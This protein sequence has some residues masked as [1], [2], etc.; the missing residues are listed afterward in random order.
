[1]ENKLLSKLKIILFSACLWGVLAHGMTLFN[2]YSFNDDIII[3]TI[4]TTYT[5]GRWMLAIL[6]DMV[7]YFTGMYPVS[8]PLFNGIFTIVFIALICVLV[9]ALLD[10]ENIWLNIGLTGMMIAFPVITGLFGFAFTAPYYLFGML[11]GVFG[12]FLVCKYSKW[13]LYLIGI[14]LMACSVGVYQANI[15]VFVSLILIYLIKV[16]AE[17]DLRWKRFLGFCIYY[18][19]ACIGFLVMYLGINKFML[20][21]NKLQLS[22]YKGINTFG[23]TSLGG[24]CNR[25]AFAYK[26][27]FDPTNGVSRNMFPFRLE[28]YYKIAIVIAVLLSIYLVYKKCKKVSC[29]I[30]LLFL[31]MLLPLAI[32]F[33]YIMCDASV[34]HSLMMYGQVFF[35]AY[36]IWIVD[37]IEFAKNKIKKTVVGIA[38]VFLLFMDMLY[39]RFDNECYLKAEFI[40]EQAISYFTTLETQIKSVAGYTDYTPVVYINENRKSDLTITR[41][42]VFDEINLLPYHYSDLVTGDSSWRLFM[43][44]WCGFNPPMADS[45]TY[46]NLPEVIQMPSYPDDGSIKMIEDVIVIKF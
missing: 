41:L 24:Y 18:G 31:M 39:C 28:R 15:P 2:K 14:F 21:K 26:E 43:A 23:R 19:A 27:F 11:M 17:K 3:F 7:A 42:P 30:Q 9:S 38:V 36:I 8:V 6:G 40:Q 32:N 35:F 16:V 5:S 4:G 34:I 20:W 13:Y 25:V 37:H 10:I 44:M 12:A 22:D 45:A 33:I 46:E 1:M 29:G